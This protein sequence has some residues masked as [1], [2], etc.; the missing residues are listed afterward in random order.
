METLRD[1]LGPF[2]P[3]RLLEEPRGVESPVYWVLLAICVVA[4]V[5]G[6]AC[7]IWPD[8]IA[9]GNRI[10]R[11][12]YSLYGQW[13]AWLGGAGILLVVLRMATIPLFSKRIW[14]A[15]NML[16]ML[17]VGLYLLRYMRTRYPEVMADYREDQRKR[18]FYPTPKRSHHGRRA[19][20]RVG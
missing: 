3:G 17:V 7:A 8:R 6:L 10:H 5:V 13:Y 15:L 12:L 18:R 2:W 11:R 1:A 19:V 20:R 14:I 16:A 4:F 9:K